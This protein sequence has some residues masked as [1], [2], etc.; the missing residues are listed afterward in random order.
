MWEEGEQPMRDR[1]SAECGHRTEVCGDEGERGVMMIGARSGARNG[2][3][4][5]GAESGWQSLRAR[6]RAYPWDPHVGIG[7][8]VCG[9]GRGC[10]CDSG[11]G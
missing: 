6:V 3:G 11:S 1:G 9:R 5:R 10:G 4:E 7:P 8:R 2:A